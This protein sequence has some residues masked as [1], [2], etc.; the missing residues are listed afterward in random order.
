M[1]YLI[2]STFIY[3]VG[4]S[5]SVKPIAYGEDMCAYCKMVIVDDQHAAIAV[6]DKGKVFKFDAI[7]CLIPYL[8]TQP[9]TSFKL[10]EVND[11]EMA[12]SMIPAETSFYLITRSIPSPMGAFLSAFATKDKAIAAQTTHG[13]ELFD[14]NQVQERLKN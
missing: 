12:G 2:L 14:W 11:Y 10:L 3:L 13:G 7:E 5:P 9:E 6:T 4:C 8:Q 1:K